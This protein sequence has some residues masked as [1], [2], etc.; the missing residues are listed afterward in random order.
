MLL[1]LSS[2]VYELREQ[3]SGH[4]DSEG[5]I[6]STCLGK[7]AGISTIISSYLPLSFPIY[8]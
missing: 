5:E 7:L 8:G 4:V 2:A 1:Y 3:S 6:T